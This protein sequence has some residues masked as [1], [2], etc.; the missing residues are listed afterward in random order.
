MDGGTSY[1]GLTLKTSPTG[2][3]QLKGKLK[4]QKVEVASAL[5]AFNRR[6]VL[7]GTASGDSVIRAS[8]ANFV[9]LVQSLQTK[10]SFVMSPATLLRFDMGKVVHSAG[11]DHSGQTALDSITGSMNTQN[12]PKGIV[13]SFNNIKA[14]SGGLDASGYATL[15]NRRLEVGFAVDLVYG[16]VGVPLAISGPTDNVQ[17]SVPRG[18][19]AGAVVGTALLPG[20][21]TAVGARIGAAVGKFLALLPPRRQTLS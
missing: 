8:G 21:G 10:T 9:E 17:V 5:S 18:A 14:R 12:T 3:L 20:S 7:A 13:V 11:Q 6:L 1:S 15:A 19:V 4:P 16:F 2:Q